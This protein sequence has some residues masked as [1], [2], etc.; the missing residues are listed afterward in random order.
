MRAGLHWRCGWRQAGAA[1]SICV[2]KDVVIEAVSSGSP[3]RMA[4]ICRRGRPL[5]SIPAAPGL[6]T[7]TRPSG[8]LLCPLEGRCHRTA[9]TGDRLR[10]PLFAGSSDARF[11]RPPVPTAGLHRVSSA[12]RRG[13]RS[14]TS[15]GRDQAAP[16]AVRTTVGPAHRSAQRLW[17]SRRAITRVNVS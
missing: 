9:A 8:P 1:H 3:G 17:R 13:L 16:M 5:C 10:R 4:F 2:P 12:L 6:N 7:F 15:P 14:A 11:L